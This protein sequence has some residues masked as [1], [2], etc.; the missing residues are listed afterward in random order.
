MNSVKT[1]TM[2]FVKDE[3]DKCIAQIMAV[4]EKGGFRLYVAWEWEVEAKKGIFGFTKSDK[5]YKTFNWED[6]NHVANRGWDISGTEEVK[7][8]FANLF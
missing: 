3:K 5:L 8:I 6:V 2:T 4:A 7:K 1:N